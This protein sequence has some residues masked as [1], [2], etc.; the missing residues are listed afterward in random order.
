MSLWGGVSDMSNVV[1]TSRQTQN[2]QER[3]HF[4]SPRGGASESGQGKDCRK[5]YPPQ[6]GPDKQKKTKKMKQI[7]KN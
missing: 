2:L 5:C 4:S 1:E 3:L 6:P 7:Q